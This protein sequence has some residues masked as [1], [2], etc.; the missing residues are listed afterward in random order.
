MARPGKFRGP[1]AHVRCKYLFICGT[2]LN[3]LDSSLGV[4]LIDKVT[5]NYLTQSSQFWVVLDNQKPIENPAIHETSHAALQHPT[6]RAFI[7]LLKAPVVYIQQAR[8]PCIYNASVRG[9]HWP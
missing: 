3:F 7:F 5:L 2:M 1:L 6:T 8:P 9:S 4:Q